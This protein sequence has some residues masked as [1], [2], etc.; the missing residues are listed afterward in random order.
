MTGKTKR[1]HP[2]NWVGTLKDFQ[3]W[4][5]SE[6][7]EQARKVILGESFEDRVVSHALRYFICDYWNDHTTPTLLL[8]SHDSVNGKSDCLTSVAVPLILINGAIDIHDDVVDRSEKKDGRPTVY[9]KFGEEIALLIGDALL[10]KGFMMLAL[11]CRNLDGEKCSDILNTLK[12]GLFELGQAEVMELRYRGLADVKPTEYL[13]VAK[14]KAADVEAL[15]RIG[16]MLG[17]AKK[18]E[19]EALGKY[20]RILGLISILR[21][22]VIDMTLQEELGHRLKHE[23]L[24]L[25]LIYAMENTKV[26]AEL[27]DLV[28]AKD[29][30]ANDYE[31]IRKLTNQGCGFERT[32]SYID[33]LRKSGEALTLRLKSKTQLRFLLTSLADVSEYELFS[34][35]A[36]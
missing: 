30:T 2:D 1:L 17:N 13:N 10:M 22:D 32:K 27:L 26:R 20:G 34:P 29:K 33:Q 8:L 23:C 35:N 19:I 21:D 4:Y 24:P 31:L 36:I 5:G 15:M 25:P 11:V 12:Q 14:K 28:G 3:E 6:A 7:V 18:S 16:A 9:G